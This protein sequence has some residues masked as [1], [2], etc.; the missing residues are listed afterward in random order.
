MIKL[1]NVEY[2]LQT[3][4]DKYIALSSYNKTTI[5]DLSKK[6]IVAE[7]VGSNGC[8][9]NIAFE[10][11]VGIAGNDIKIIALNSMQIVYKFSPRDVVKRYALPEKYRKKPYY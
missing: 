11:Y 7:F 8:Y 1:K 2:V 10:N 3:G 4:I 6:E 5:Y 9:F